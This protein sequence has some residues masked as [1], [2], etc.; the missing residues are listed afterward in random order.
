M[1]LETKIRKLEE[2]KY[3]VL[4]MTLKQILRS[5]NLLTEFNIKTPYP[6]IGAHPSFIASDPATVNEEIPGCSV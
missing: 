5:Y 3:P 6:E 1:R 4:D 2:L